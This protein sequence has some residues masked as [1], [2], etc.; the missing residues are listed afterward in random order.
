MMLLVIA[1]A[2]KFPRVRYSTSFWWACQKEG[3]ENCHAHLHGTVNPLSDRK[4]EW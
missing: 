3:L 1:V 4:L 2:R